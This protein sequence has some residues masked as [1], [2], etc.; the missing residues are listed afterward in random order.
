MWHKSSPKSRN[1]SENLGSRAK[2]PRRLAAAAL[3]S[4]VSRRQSIGVPPIRT[5]AVGVRVTPSLQPWSPCH[6]EQPPARE[7]I[8]T[9]RCPLPRPAAGPTPAAGDPFRRISAQLTERKA[10]RCETHRWPPRSRPMLT[11]PVSPF[12]VVSV[13]RH[14]PLAR[15]RPSH[16]LA[17]CPLAANGHFYLSHAP[18]LRR[19]NH[20]AD[21]CQAPVTTPAAAED[22]VL[23]LTFA[24]SVTSLAGVNP[25]A[26]CCM[27]APSGTA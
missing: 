3:Y 21:F 5:V 1:A 4:T 25:R 26:W 16:C 20:L 18:P 12:V 24:R 6:R 14:H 15:E 17:A 10:A 22:P 13:P 27:S 7:A 19:L 8:R 11:K 23:V 9:H 2:T